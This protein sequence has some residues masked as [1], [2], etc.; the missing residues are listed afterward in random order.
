MT[1]RTEATRKARKGLGAERRNE[2]VGDF[3]ELL[4]Q[5]A[6]AAGVTPVVLPLASSVVGTGLGRETIGPAHCLK[7]CSEATECELAFGRS[8]ME[9]RVKG[10]VATFIQIGEKHCQT[11]DV[12]FAKHRPQLV[13]VFA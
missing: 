9:R 1:L 6:L 7:P 3:S 13:L 10:L 4:N 11:F 5:T 2:R 8:C 12:T